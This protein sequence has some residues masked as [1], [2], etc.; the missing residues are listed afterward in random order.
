[1]YV[2]HD[3]FYPQMLVYS[4]CF[5][6]WMHLDAVSIKMVLKIIDADNFT[7]FTLILTVTLFKK[8]SRPTVRTFRTEKMKF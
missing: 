8:I 5:N 4:L 7:F 1:M 3:S 6:F 2:T